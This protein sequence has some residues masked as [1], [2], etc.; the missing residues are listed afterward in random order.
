MTKLTFAIWL[1]TF[2]DEKGFD[3]DMSFDV[4]GPS[5][6]NM[7]D[8]NV[9]MQAILDTN[10]NEQEGIKATL[11]KIDF[12]NGEGYWRTAKTS[13]DPGAGLSSHLKRLE[14]KSK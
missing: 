2:I 5:G 7:M 6:T 12:M 11:V 8:Y 9:V 3:T 4:E 14:D 10:L 1:D 13:A